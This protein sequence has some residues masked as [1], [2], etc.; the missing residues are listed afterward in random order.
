MARVLVLGAAAMDTVARVKAFPKTDDIVFPDEIVR[1]PGGSAANVAVAL[2]RLGAAVSF[3]GTV[4]TDADGEAIA[5]AFHDERV[6]TA[7]LLRLPNGRTAGAFIAVDQNGERIMYSL[8]GDALYSDVSLLDGIDFTAGAL[9]IAEAF[10]EVGMEAARRVHACG[11]R[12]YFAPGGVMCGYGLG[13]IRPLVEVCDTMIVSMPEL[14]KLTGATEAE[15]GS[16]VLLGA[17]AKA[18]V[19]TQGARGAGLY[20]D[21]GSIFAAGVPAVPLD[22]TGAGDAF[23]AA[24]LFSELRGSEPGARLAFANRCAAFAVGRFGA[25]TSPRLHEIDREELS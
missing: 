14:I 23:A 8:G 22:T 4:G 10:S 25:R 20:T 17:G 9:Y 13:G 18:V 6:N 16:A 12:V 24:Y 15:I 7:H 3:L 11:G 21:A 2:A 19:V 1:V 5:R